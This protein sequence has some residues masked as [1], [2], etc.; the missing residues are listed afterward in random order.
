M[1]DK[2]LL[3]IK[4]VEILVAK[5]MFQANNNLC[6]NKFPSRL[7]SEIMCLVVD[8]YQ[9]K[10]LITQKDLE[11]K[12]DVS[13]ATISEALGKM[14]SYDLIT[15]EIDKNDARIKIIKPTKKSLEIKKKIKNDLDD[16][17]TLISSFVSKEE[18]IQL[19]NILLKIINGIEIELNKKNKIEL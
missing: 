4:K 9:K 17:N 19:N 1:E 12:L 7:Q 8:A 13:R 3:Q 2:I 5:L 11:K 16:V 18:I 6:A 10:E 14:E 15:R